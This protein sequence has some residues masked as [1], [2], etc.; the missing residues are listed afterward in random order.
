[1]ES[2]SLSGEMLVEADDTR[3]R[4]FPFSN[5]CFSLL[6]HLWLLSVIK[7]FNF[8]ICSQKKH[9]TAT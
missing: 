3:S 2:F 7:P 5:R 4:F 8:F 1:M 9:F 6:F